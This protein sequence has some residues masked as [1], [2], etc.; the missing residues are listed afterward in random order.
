MLTDTK[1]VSLV[2]RTPLLYVKEKILALRHIKAWLVI[3]YIAHLFMVVDITTE[4]YTDI[5]MIVTTIQR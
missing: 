2:R 4:S 1:S 5:N 3:F